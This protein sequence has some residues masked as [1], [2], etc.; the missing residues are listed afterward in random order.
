MTN[1][2]N[3]YIL[4]ATVVCVVVAAIVDV[5]SNKIPNWLTFPS[6]VL[7]LLINSYLEGVHGLASSI[8]GLGTGFLLLFVIYLLGGMGAGDVKLLS[9]IGALLGPKLV[10]YTFIWMALSGGLLAIALVIY[11]KAFSQTLRNLKT[12]LLGWILRV[13]N[14]HANLTIKNQS[15]IKLPY[16]VAIAIGAIF[17]VCFRRVPNLGL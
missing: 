8:F 7:G 4:I 9:A 10:I 2:I 13:S 14:E 1:P 12:L 16:G 6:T 11:K 5:L 15:L 17:A 3:T